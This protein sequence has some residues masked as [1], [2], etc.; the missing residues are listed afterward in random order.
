LELNDV[1]FSDGGHTHCL[2]RGDTELAGHQ[3]HRKRDLIEDEGRHR[4]GQR[5]QAKRK[6]SH[7][8]VAPAVQLHD[9]TRQHTE[10]RNPGQEELERGLPDEKEDEAGRH[11]R[12]AGV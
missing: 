7:P 12:G 9:H 6:E 8:Q 10:Q 1:P 4:N 5:Q 2:E 11:D 3:L